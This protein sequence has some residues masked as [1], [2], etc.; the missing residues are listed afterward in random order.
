[1][2]MMEILN[3]S[4]SSKQT[5]STVRKLKVDVYGIDVQINEKIQITVAGSHRVVLTFNDPNDMAPK[6]EF[7]WRVPS[8]LIPNPGF[9]F[10]QWPNHLLYIFNQPRIRNLVFDGVPC[11][12]DLLSFRRTFDKFQSLTIHSTCPDHVAQEVLNNFRPKN[13]LVLKKHMPDIDHYITSNLDEIHMKTIIELDQLLIMNSNLISIR[14]P[15]FS[16]RD[17]N[18]F[19]KL[20]IAGSN[21]NLEVLGIV[22]ESPPGLEMNKVLKGISHENVPDDVGRKFTDWR[23]ERLS[24]VVYGGINIRRRGD[25]AIATI[26][27]VADNRIFYMYVSPS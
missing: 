2:P 26:K 14:T 11:I 3:F 19:L 12:Q 23:I 17:M 27:Y 6:A 21:R 18:R 15:K 8:Q 16:S 25:G 7:R 10:E 4:L 22:F 13:K 9:R 1:M 24:W 5:K 20:W